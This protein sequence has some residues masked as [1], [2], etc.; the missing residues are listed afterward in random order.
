MGRGPV[1]A[2][3]LLGL[4]AFLLTFLTFASVGVKLPAVIQS[5]PTSCHVPPRPGWRVA[6][7]ATANVRFGA[8]SGPKSD[9]APSP[10][11]PGVPKFCVIFWVNHRCVSVYQRSVC[12]I[13]YNSLR[14]SDNYHRFVGILPCRH[15]LRVKPGP[16]SQ[17]SHTSAPQPRAEVPAR[18]R[19]VGEVPISD[20]AFLPTARLFQ[21]TN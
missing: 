4:A 2:Y 8:L 20:I 13:W 19:H 21:Q 11:C 10:S 7:L 6:G 3:L 14:L 5:L 17:V 15:A 16:H 12:M 9:V 1:A 18:S